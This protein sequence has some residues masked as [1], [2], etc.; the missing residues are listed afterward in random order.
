MASPALSAIA[1]NAVRGHVSAPKMRRSAVRRSAVAAAGYSQKGQ[2]GFHNIWSIPKSKEAEFDKV[3]EIHEKWMNESHFVGP[4]GD[5][6]K[7]PRLSEYMISK[8]DE[9]T[10]PFDIGSSPTGNV[11]YVMN[12]LYYDQAGIAK[13]FE[14]GQQQPWFADIL[15]FLNDHGVAID[16]GS[17]TAIHTFSDEVEDCTI[18]KGDTNIAVCFRVP[19][20]NVVEVENFFR[21]H[22]AFMRDSH[23]WMGSGDDLKAP[24]LTHYTVCKGQEL[25]DPLDASKGFTDDWLF[26]LNE[27]Y[28]S[29]EGVQGHMKVAQEQVPEL[30][31]EFVSISER[32]CYH[33]SI[34]TT[35]T[36]TMD[37]GPISN[38]IKLFKKAV[39]TVTSSVGGEK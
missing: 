32:F 24:R 28:M 26:F 19:S 38:I 11:V 34:N 27:T 21:K 22:E 6:S 15:A 16:A 7:G 35:V 9:L 20:K 13:H 2:S 4:A 36:H 1:P 3:W 14:L 12:E 33:T 18:R 17:T 8:G 31:A 5:D 10:D 29:P 30:F 37:K 25:K 23:Q 39:K